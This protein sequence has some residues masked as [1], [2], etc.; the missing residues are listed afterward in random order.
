[1]IIKPLRI[2]DEGGIHEIVIVFALAGF[3][4]LNIQSIGFQLGKIPF[5]ILSFKIV[6]K[7][8]IMTSGSL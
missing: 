4:A 6:D 5:Q 8:D 2:A 7:S 1:M 3:G